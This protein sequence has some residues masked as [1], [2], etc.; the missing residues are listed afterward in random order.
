MK[1]RINSKYVKERVND[2]LEEDID[3]S[4]YNKWILSRYKNDDVRITCF[5]GEEALFI[6]SQ[7]CRYWE[8]A[9][10]FIKAFMKAFRIAI[11][12]KF[13]NAQIKA[14]EPQKYRYTEAYEITIN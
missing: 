3:T 12:A 6:H 1:Y 4:K 14:L 8:D 13:E 2:F 7:E 10:S 5:K 11:F 9:E